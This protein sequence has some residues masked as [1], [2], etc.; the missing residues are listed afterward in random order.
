MKPAPKKPLPAEISQQTQAQLGTNYTG[1]LASNKFFTPQELNQ[2]I[3]KSKPMRPP[4]G[5]R[6]VKQE[7]KKA[8]VPNPMAQTQQ[9]QFNS[10]Q[11][12]FYSAA[13]IG[14]E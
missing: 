10:S 5:N 4:S 11:S 13:D 6:V 2:K 1:K 7:L 3:G 8:E 14:Q 9:D 12:S